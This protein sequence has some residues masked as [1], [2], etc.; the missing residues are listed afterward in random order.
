MATA[1]GGVCGGS[2]VLIGA[3]LVTAKRKWLAWPAAALLCAGLAAIVAWFDVFFMAVLFFS[4]WSR[5]ALVWFAVLSVLAAMT[6]LLLRL[7]CDREA[8]P[9]GTFGTTRPMATRTAFCLLL[10]ALAL[11]PAYVAWELNHPLP[12]PDL[13]VPQPNGIDDIVAAGTALASS[14]IL[15][16]SVEP[17]STEELA[18]EVAKYA[19]DYSRLRLGLTRDI[20]ATVWAKDGKI[21]TAAVFSLAPLDV[22]QAVREAARALMREAQLAQQQNRYGDAA[23]IALDN[24]HLGQAVAL[25]SLL[26]D[27]LTGAAVEDI[28][29]ESLYQVLPQLNAGQCREMIAAL[30]AIERRREPIEDALHRERICSEHSF[31]W[32]G[33]LHDLVIRLAS[34]DHRQRM[35]GLRDC[36]QAKT[37]L[38]IGELALHACQLEHGALPDQLEQLV[39]EFLA[40]LPVDP[41]DPDGQ[42]LRYIRAEDGHVLYSVGYDGKDDGGRPP[43]RNPSGAYELESDGDLRL[44]VFFSRDDDGSTS[45]RSPVRK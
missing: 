12:V 2:A 4:S 43:A 20:L 26:V 40:E 15:S 17:K 22:R 34:V 18:A 39:P 32:M 41:F 9:V 23:R 3:W 36:Q 7:G 11:P 35:L 14:P 6:W 8:T 5:V 45:A 25:G 21:D 29:N 1:L 16:T 30:A 42:P 31:G 33:H 37:R 38:L 44:N 27:Y 19:G 13:P 28:G 24:V 10:V